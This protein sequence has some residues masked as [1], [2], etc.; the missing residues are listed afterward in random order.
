[1]KIGL[2]LGGGA[3]RGLAHIGV[4]RALLES[5]IRIDLV[6]GS[7][8]GAIIGAMFAQH[9]D[10]DEVQQ[11][12]AAYLQS[13]EFEKA[14]LDFLREKEAD[15]GAGIFFRFSQFAKRSMFYTL[16]LTRPSF[17]SMETAQ[18]N[19]AF[20]VE[21]AIIEEL[22]LPFAAVALDLIA[23]EKFVF[24][25]GSLR[26]ALSA[27]CAI[28]GILPA[29]SKDDR[30]LVDGGWIDS[31]PV[32]AARQLG[33]DVV[34]AVDVNP[35]LPPANGLDS[36]LD[37]VFRADAIARFALGNERR[38]GADLLLLPPDILTHWA[39]F[40][41]MDE[42]VETAYIYTTGQIPR[43]KKILARQR[44]RNLWPF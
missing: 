15:E 33:A 8:M 41:R 2:A 26:E 20:L 37:I 28:P 42:T 22:P 32:S 24:T 3:A 31:V 13:E 10:I 4:I 19:F 25:Q 43:L 14:R 38:Q 35:A 12:F 16:A 9:R 21:D 29:L 5:G 17:L 6:A 18:S 40:S 44:L 23:A 39:D 1:M 7:S 27:S 11:R 30:L 36:G 34:I